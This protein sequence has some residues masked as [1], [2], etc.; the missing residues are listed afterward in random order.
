MHYGFSFVDPKGT[1]GGKKQLH[2][3]SVLDINFAACPINLFAFCHSHGSD[4]DEK[5]IMLKMYFW[6]YREYS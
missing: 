4:W 5:S 6:F 3:I 2:I 1:C